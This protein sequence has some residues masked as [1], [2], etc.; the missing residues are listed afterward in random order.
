VKKRKEG[1]KEGRK[2]QRKRRLPDT[3]E[4]TN[5]KNTKEKRRRLEYEG[6][7]TEMEENEVIKST[8]KYR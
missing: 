1:R 6:D 8:Q 4:L 7:K 5:K 3:S 2:K